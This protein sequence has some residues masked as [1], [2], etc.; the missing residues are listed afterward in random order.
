VPDAV[1]NGH[2]RDRLPNTL[3]ISFPGRVAGDILALLPDVALSAGAACHSS[4]VHVSHVLSAMG[5]PVSVAVGTI[6]ASVGRM[7]T[8]AEIDDAAERIG[9]AV[10]AVA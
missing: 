8:V 4:G 3:S 10:S 1:V 5:I 2:P 7:T 9:A 6:R